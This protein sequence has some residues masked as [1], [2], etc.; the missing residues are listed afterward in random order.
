MYLV[1]E[2]YSGLV[3]T[4][5]GRGWP[6]PSIT[7]LDEHDNQLTRSHIIKSNDT[8]MA[9]LNFGSNESY[10]QVQCRAMNMYGTES[11][12]IQIIRGRVNGVSPLT[13]LEPENSRL[14]QFRLQF[15]DIYCTNWNVSIVALWKY[16]FY[17]FL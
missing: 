17:Q 5:V 15:Q 11:L 1:Q 3:L 13:P 6:A 16:D 14:I 4:C 8:V 9:E 10:S 12:D 2:D 7:W